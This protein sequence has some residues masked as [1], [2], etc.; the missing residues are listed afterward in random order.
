M[1][2]DPAFVILFTIQVVLLWCLKWC[3][4]LDRRNAETAS[5]QWLT[6]PETRSRPPSAV[7]ADRETPLLSR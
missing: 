6:V 4:Q 5:R 7:F 2:I 3:E 1:I